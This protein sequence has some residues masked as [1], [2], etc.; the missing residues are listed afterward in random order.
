MKVGMIGM[1]NLGSAVALLAASHGHEVTGWEFDAA[2]VASINEKQANDRYLPGIP[3]PPSVQA[4]TNL[5]EVMALPLVFLALPSRFVLPVLSRYV[6]AHPAGPWPAIANLSKGIDAASGKTVMMMLGTLFPEEKLAMVA[7]PSLANEFSRGVMTV[8]VAASKNS[9]LVQ[10]VGKV[11]NG[12]RF[13]VLPSDDV[14]GVE[15]GGILKNIYA[16][17]LGIFAAQGELGLNF[18]GAYLTQAL[19]EMQA[20][21]SILGARPE[22]FLLPSGI[23]DLIATSLS[24]HSHN[25][26]MGRL[27]GEGHSL[28]EVR[29][30]MGNLPEGYNTLQ[31]AVSLAQK[32]GITLPLATL[33]HEVV[34]GKL[35]PEQ[36][37]ERFVG[38]L[39]ATHP[40]GSTPHR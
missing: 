26:T 34:E 6:A 9:A 38:V 30:K 31:V 8:V 24:E 4:T 7:G 5:D 29:E 3:L 14:S 23:G 1:G 12:S 20:L 28:A 18:V 37:M 32:N 25:R 22:S 19:A 33:L 35:P 36:F 21:G 27:I 10:Q 13:A 15:L 17:G 11:L 16:L 2:V 39:S 40:N